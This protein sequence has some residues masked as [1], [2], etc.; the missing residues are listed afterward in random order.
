MNVLSIVG[1]A[2]AL[3]MDAFAVSVGLSIARNGLDR[4][5]GFRLALHFGVFQSVM[6][7][8]GWAAGRSLVR[9]IG[10]Y[11]HWAAAALLVFVGGKMIVES[12]HKEEHILREKRDMT[13]G[14][15]LI[16]LSVATSLDALAVGLSFGALRWPIL[17][18]AGIIGAVCAMV[19]AAGTKIGPVLGKFA[20]KW[21][22]LAG[23][24]VLI[25]IAVKILIDHL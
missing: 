22:E 2:L 21:A 12:F 7:I 15:S 17:A 25:L 24:T 23:G 20:G 6:P 9:L 11:D 4:G 8:L 1:V 5:Q 18:P 19:T 3:S 13:R 16:L 14:F 10:A